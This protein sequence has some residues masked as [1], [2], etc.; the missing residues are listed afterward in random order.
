M[1][2]WYLFMEKKFEVFQKKKKKKGNSFI[3]WP[4]SM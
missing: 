2:T 1:Q 3:E 4:L